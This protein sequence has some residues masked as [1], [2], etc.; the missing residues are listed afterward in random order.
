VRD[1]TNLQ[2]TSFLSFDKPCWLAKVVITARG[3]SEALTC[4]GETLVVNRH[5]AL[6]CST[7]PLR[8]GLLGEFEVV[9]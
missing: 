8:F 4:D 2:V 1:A 6:I 5:G 9:V 7:V 3:V